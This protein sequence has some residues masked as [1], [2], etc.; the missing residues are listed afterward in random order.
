MSLQLFSEPCLVRV[1]YNIQ[2]TIYCKLP[3]FVLRSELADL[4]GNSARLLDES[5]LQSEYARRHTWLNCIHQTGPP[6][7]YQQYARKPDPSTFG[8]NTHMF[9]EQSLRAWHNVMSGADEERWWGFFLCRKAAEE[10]SSDSPSD[11]TAEQVLAEDL[12]R[13]GWKYKFQYFII[14][15]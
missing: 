8:F 7:L 9:Y 3:L 10:Q 2:Y 4:I 13:N 6:W 1:I 15:W 5:W 11:I 12:F 14:R